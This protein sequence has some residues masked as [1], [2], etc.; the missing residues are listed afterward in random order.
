MAIG[1]SIYK[2]SAL[3]Q[4]FVDQ[5][6]M[7]HGLHN[8]KSHFTGPYLYTQWHISLIYTTL[9]SQIKGNNRDIFQI[10]PDHRDIL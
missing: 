3:V 2:I 9:T 7:H 4:L 1:L 6:I 10:Y 8:S 5:M